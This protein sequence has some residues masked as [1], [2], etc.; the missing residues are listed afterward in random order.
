MEKVYEL[1]SGG[2]ELSHFVSV[3][4]LMEYHESTAKQDFHNHVG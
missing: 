1:M 4:F 3:L 2:A